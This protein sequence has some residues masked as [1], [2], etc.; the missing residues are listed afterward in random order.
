MEWQLFL[1]STIVS[2]TCLLALFLASLLGCGPPL[3][4][5]RCLSSCLLLLEQPSSSLVSSLLLLQPLGSCCWGSNS[6]LA[7]L[8]SRACPAGGWVGC[9]LFFLHMLRIPLKGK[10]HMQHQPQVSAQTQGQCTNNLS[11]AGLGW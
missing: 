6:L 9:L 10:T 4:M 7:L 1:L 5:L 2:K 3:G 8:L 11:A